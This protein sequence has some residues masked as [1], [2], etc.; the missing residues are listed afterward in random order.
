M[1]KLWLAALI[2]SFCSFA[3]AADNINFRDA[4]VTAKFK[5][6]EVR[7]AVLETVTPA[8]EL[9]PAVTK[10]LELAI[11]E[12]QLDLPFPIYS[13]KVM[14]DGKD[15]TYSYRNDMTLEGKE[16][17]VLVHYRIKDKDDTSKVRAYSGFI[18]ESWDQV[19]ASPVYTKNFKETKADALAVTSAEGITEKYKGVDA[20]ETVPMYPGMCGAPLKIEAA[21]EITEEPIER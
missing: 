17:M 9:T 11:Y 19:K 14:L 8:T 2:V 12:M 15:V 13:E 4:V 5:K 3:Y 1:K 20:A 16:A 6:V 10:E 21:K 7:P 18:G